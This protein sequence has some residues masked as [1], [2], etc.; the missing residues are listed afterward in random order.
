MET[1]SKDP[2]SRESA[3]RRFLRERIKGTRFSTI[4]ELLHAA[5]VPASSVSMV[6]SGR[7]DLREKHAVQIARVLNTLSE[8]NADGET[9]N[10]LVENLLKL[11]TRSDIEPRVDRATS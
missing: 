9:L 8:P 2:L 4:A 7:R 5:G 3:L 6:F 11:G 1:S 10:D